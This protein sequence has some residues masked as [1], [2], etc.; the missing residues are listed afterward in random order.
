VQRSN[1]GGRETGETLSRQFGAKLCESCMRL[2]PFFLLETRGQQ[3]LRRFQRLFHT[4]PIRRKSS[5]ESGL[6]AFALP[7][8]IVHNSGRIGDL[9]ETFASTVEIRE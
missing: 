8:E 6:A 4:T 1:V 2:S 5:T 7:H 3:I 9:A